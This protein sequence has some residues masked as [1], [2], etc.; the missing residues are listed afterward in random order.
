MPATGICAHRRQTGF[1]LLEM[2]VVVIVLGLLMVGLT[3][4]VRTGIALWG[5]Q[6]RR[7]GQTAELDAGARILRVLLTGISTPAASAVGGTA[8]DDA[9]SGNAGQVKFVGDLPTGLG[10]TRRAEITIVLRKGNLVLSWTPHRH[11]I[12]LGPLPAP[13]ETELVANVARLEIAYWGSTAPDQPEAWQAR[14]DGPAPPELIRIHL[15]FA[16]TDRRRWPDLVA[17]PVL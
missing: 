8:N 13:S 5:A 16:K 15:G 10:T 2:L 12:P 17:A 1:T 4:G 9:F 3:Q 7:V 11:E 6:Q 14:W